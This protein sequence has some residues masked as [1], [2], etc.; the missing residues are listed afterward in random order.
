M[1]YDY[2]NVNETSEE[3]LELR[4]GKIQN[5]AEKKMISSDSNREYQG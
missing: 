5:S 1:N 3:E 4:T 2:E